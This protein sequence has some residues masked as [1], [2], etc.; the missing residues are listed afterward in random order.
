MNEVNYNEIIVVPHLQRK[1]QELTNQV[2][3]LEVN[4]M[5]EQAKNKALNEKIKQLEAVKEPP[6]K[7]KKTENVLDG[8]TY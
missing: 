4:L 2:L 6:S 1:H 8:E 3:I 7:K 5:I